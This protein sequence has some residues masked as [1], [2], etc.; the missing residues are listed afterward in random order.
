VSR[1]LN[2]YGSYEFEASARSL[3]RYNVE[4]FGLMLVEMG[5]AHPEIMDECIGDVKKTLIE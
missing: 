5:H 3:I 4:F 2:W 1:A